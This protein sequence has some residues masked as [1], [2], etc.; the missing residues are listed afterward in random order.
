MGAQLRRFWFKFKGGAYSPLGY[1][2]TAWTEDDAKAI[3]A[4]HV[5]NGRPLPDFDMQA[6]V[7]LKT[8]DTKH[9]LPNMEAPTWRGIWFPR[10]YAEAN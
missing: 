9:V 8:L 7:D 6:D 3:L 1:G 4:S 10:G 2:V 5:F